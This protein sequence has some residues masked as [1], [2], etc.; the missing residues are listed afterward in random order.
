M[1]NRYE[2]GAAEGD[3]P[4]FR[5]GDCPVFR[6]HDSATPTGPDRKTGLSPSAVPLRIFAVGRSDAG[7]APGGGEIQMTSTVAALRSLGVAAR[8]WRLA[9]G[10]WDKAD[11]I[12]LFGSLPEHLPVVEAAWRR[13]VPTVL[14]TIAWFDWADYW[15]G[16]TSLPGRVAAV[17]RFAARAACPRL[18]SWRRR[19]YQSVD[20]LL[21]NS[22]A[23]AEQLMRYFGIP[24]ERI[25]VV[26]NGADP[27]FADADPRIFA[28]RFGP[29]WFVLCPGRIE[30][31]KNQL[32]LVRAMRGVDVPLVV[33]GQ[34]VP[35]HEDYLDACRREAGESVVFLDRIE[36]D[37][38]LLGAAYAACGCLALA[39]WFETPGLVA[40]E[41]AMSGTP[42]VLPVGGS[43]TEYFGPHAEY[44]RPHDPREIRRAVLRSL[45]AGRSPTL[46]EHVRE[47]FSWD[48][49]AKATLAA[50]EV[51]VG[52]AEGDS[53]VFRS[54]P[55]E[56]A[57]SCGRKTGQ[58]PRYRYVRLRWRVMFAAI[59]FLGAL[60]FGAGRLV[61]WRKRTIPFFGRRRLGWLSHAAEKRDSPQAVEG[62]SPV[63]RSAPVEVAESC[64]R[65][66]G[67]SPGWKLGQ[68][69]G[70]PADDPRTILII[71]LDHLGDA[72]L[73]TG[74]IAVLRRRYPRASIEV[75][76]GR[77]N[78]ELFAAIDAVNR[79]HVSRLNRFSRAGR[80]GWPLAVFWWGWRLRRRRFDLGIDVRGEFP[81]ALILWL[82][83]VRQR[84]GWAAGGGG[85]L[86]TDSPA[87]VPN[88][89][90]TESRGAL[91]AQLGITLDRPEELWP[92]FRAPE[93]VGQ[94][95]RRQLDIHGPRGRFVAVHV[96]AGTSAKMWPVE[97]WQS[98]VGRLVVEHGIEIVLVGSRADGTIAQAILAGKTWPGVY[99]WTGRSTVVELV[100]LLEQ[101][102]V[103]VGA[104]SGPVHLAA[105]VGR[106]VVVLASGTNCP[107]QWQPRGRRV[108][109]IDHPMPC[110]PCHR[111]RCPREDHPCMN[112]LRPEE[113]VAAVLETL[114]QQ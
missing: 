35:G 10:R 72:V 57:E 114:E 101:A 82:A 87:F 105:A 64:G 66:T 59:D 49:A 73:S 29:R 74:M 48:A 51:A 45:A 34:V 97:H 58:S 55:V 32:G 76:T 6:P 67:Q 75:L 37:D 19:L 25:R 38:P 88:R 16:G 85:F 78:R 39:S 27:R 81:L 24:A 93:Q 89:P 2:N 112:R 79:V 92:I 71:Q 26:P 111:D 5:S 110:S 47:N 30:P 8:P 22:T 56:V 23:E 68:S 113:I 9:E 20:L 106:P 33:L 109:V 65:K 1:T 40:L 80:F 18:P 102:E 95:I 94:K 44:V 100:A 54:A 69:P 83:G 28:D 41:A 4:V 84:L 108:T 86:L 42:L 12:H 21:P 70:A 61:G 91:L 17:A 60:V 3:C 46:A 103:V 53:P 90:E 104:D 62:D 77:W 63:F 36:H 31:R 50:Y 98:L 52:R 15:R 13:G 107:R 14:S 96:G 7:L 99:D 43:A 11:C